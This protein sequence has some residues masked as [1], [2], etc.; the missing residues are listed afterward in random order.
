MA[1]PKGSKASVGEP[2]LKPA[3][4]TA[5]ETQLG[6]KLLDSDHGDLQETLGPSDIL[7]YIYG[8]L[9][10]P[11]YRERYAPFLKVDFPRVPL[12]SERKLFA[13]LVEK[14][15]ELISFHLLESPMLS[16]FITRYEEPGE[17]AIEKVHYVEPNAKAGITAG[18]VYINDTQYFDGVTKE[19]W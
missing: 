15:R 7:S 10:S 4:I 17:H 19:I 11:K 6:L 2:N 8:I 13:A 18:R 16:R 1:W 5:I 9:H 12:T 14:G 3:F